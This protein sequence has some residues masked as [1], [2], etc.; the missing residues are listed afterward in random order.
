MVAVLPH[1]SVRGVCGLIAC[2]VI[3]MFHT[4]A[5]SLVSSS[6]LVSEAPQTAPNLRQKQ[7]GG[8]FQAKMGPLQHYLF[9][10]RPLA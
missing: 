7:E 6:D 5:V 4:I 8:P 3:L 2:A 10:L 9:L 1:I